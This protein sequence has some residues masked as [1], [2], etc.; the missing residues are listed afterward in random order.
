V[1]IYSY[2]GWVIFDLVKGYYVVYKEQYGTFGLYMMCELANSIVTLFVIMPAR[3]YGGVEAVI[4]LAK[5]RMG[6]VKFQ[7]VQ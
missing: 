6:I 4:Q 7:G 1:F 2:L 5:K 3:F